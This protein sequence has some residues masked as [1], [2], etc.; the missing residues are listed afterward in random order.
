MYTKSGLRY[1]RP[2]ACLAEITLG[3]LQ[4]HIKSGR[5]PVS[6]SLRD[7]SSSLRHSA[8]ISFASLTYG[9]YSA[10]SGPFSTAVRLDASMDVSF[11]LI[12]PAL[13]LASLKRL[14]IADSERFGCSSFRKKACML[15]SVH[16]WCFSRSFLMALA[17]SFTLEHDVQV[18]YQP[19]L[20]PRCLCHLCWTVS[21]G[22]G[23]E[24]SGAS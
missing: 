17:T 19:W 7:A 5:K 13:F 10:L 1:V 12:L 15:P 9:R 16:C 18:C 14:L 11:L 3:S 22:M 24:R 4:T 2:V 21:I 23:S 8:R 20:E 6:S